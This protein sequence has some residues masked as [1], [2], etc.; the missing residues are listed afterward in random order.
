M[1]FSSSVPDTCTVS[2]PGWYTDPAAEAQLR[3]WDG[4]AWT[5]WL[6]DESREVRSA[7]QAPD[8]AWPPPPERTPGAVV[9]GT[10]HA[11]AGA[12][13]LPLAALLAIA[14]VTNLLFLALPN[15]LL[16]PVGYQ[17]DDTSIFFLWCWVAAVDALWV[18][19][20]LWVLRWRTPR[21]LAIGIVV[22]AVAAVPIV[23]AARTRLPHNPIPEYRHSLDILERRVQALQSLGPEDVRTR[24]NY[25]FDGTSDRAHV[26]RHY[27]VRAGTAEATMAAIQEFFL[28]RGYERSWRAV[29]DPTYVPNPS[30]VMLSGSNT[31]VDVTDE[32]GPLG[33]RIDV[34]L[35][36]QSCSP[37]E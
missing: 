14:V 17:F 37:L 24:C 22:V 30:R 1:S 9:P 7:D 25:V 4:N 12:E 20:V 26:L 3:Y 36:R 35:E 31:I 13:H 2:G 34:L 33:E 23:L 6:T 5:A 29:H 21:R 18:V 8:R 10:A 28:A 32:S 19:A 27:E 15:L 11:S 16:L